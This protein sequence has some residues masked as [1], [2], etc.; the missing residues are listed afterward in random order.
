PRQVR[1]TTLG[2]QL[3]KDSNSYFSWD[4]THSRKVWTKSPEKLL[5]SKA[6]VNKKSGW[7]KRKEVKVFKSGK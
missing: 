1:K 6:L 3:L 7:D 2:K 4:E 5:E